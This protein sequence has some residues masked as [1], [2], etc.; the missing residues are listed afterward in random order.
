MFYSRKTEADYDGSSSDENGYNADDKMYAIQTG[1]EY[2]NNLE[3]SLVLHYNN[4]DRQYENGGYLDTYYSSH[5]LQKV[6]EVLNIL[7][8]FFLV[9]GQNIN[10]IGPISQ[11]MVRGL[12]LLPKVLLII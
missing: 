8:N 6:K 2:K 9:L 10:M 7:I 3:D 4:Y 1:I 12:H 5:L 11:I